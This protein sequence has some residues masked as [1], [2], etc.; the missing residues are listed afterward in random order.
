MENTRRILGP[1]P[2]ALFGKKSKN[3]AFNVSVGTKKNEIFIRAER[4]PVG[5][6]Y[7]AKMAYANMRGNMPC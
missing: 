1:S 7:G 2:S 6:S 4:T 5:L 3:I